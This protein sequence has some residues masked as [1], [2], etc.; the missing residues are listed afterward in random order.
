MT[1]GPASAISIDGPEAAV[2]GA[3]L[4][5]LSKWLRIAFT[6]LSL[7]GVAA[8]NSV[9]LPLEVQAAGHGFVN[10]I[11]QDVRWNMF[12]ADPRGVDLGLWASIEHTDGTATTWTIDRSVVGGDLQYYRLVQWTEAAVLLAPREQLV[13][14]AKWLA[15]EST[16]P[17]ARVTI[18]GSQRDPSPPNAPRPPTRVAVL[19]EMDNSA[20]NDLSSSDG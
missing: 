3:Q 12:S 2:S 17:V 18:F 6:L 1:P 4:H 15:S 7:S 13:G 8:A 20:L 11:G 10:T 14:L 5:P 19:L 16:K 9:W